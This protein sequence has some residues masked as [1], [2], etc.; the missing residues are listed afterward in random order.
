[1]KERVRAREEGRPVRPAS[2]ARSVV[3]RGRVA[4]RSQGRYAPPVG[5]SQVRVWLSLSRRRASSSPRSSSTS[6]SWPGWRVRAPGGVRETSGRQSGAD[7]RGIAGGIA[8]QAPGS[9][10]PQGPLK[11]TAMAYALRSRP[12]APPA[13]GARPIHARVGGEAGHVRSVALEANPHS[14]AVAPRQVPIAPRWQ[15]RSPS[16]R[17]PLRPASARSKRRAA[18]SSAWPS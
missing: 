5:A 1:M 12:P 14:G 17:L 11:A 7:A 9:A 2:R 16:R 4:P 3:S 8:P 15:T 10:L 6:S 13:R 18:S